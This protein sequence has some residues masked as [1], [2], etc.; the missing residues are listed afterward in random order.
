M[1]QRVR[2]TRMAAALAA[3]ASLGGCISAPT[4]QTLPPMCEASTDCDEAKGEWCGEGVCWG[5]PPAETGFAAVLVP[6][7]DRVDLPV[8][9]IPHLSIASD[10]NVTGLE[11]PD[12]V[13]VHGRVVLTCPEGP[14]G[15][16]PYPCGNQASVGAQILIERAPAFQGGPPY[17]RTVVAAAGVVPDQDA[18]SFLLPHDAE[19]EYRITIQPDDAVGGDDVASGEI[20]PPRQILL[21]A[22]KDRQVNWSIGE[23]SELKIIRGCV[24][25]V[26]GDGA[27]Y[28]GMK[29][30]AFGRWTQLSPLERASSRS[31][32]GEDGCFELSVPRNMLDQFDISVQPQPGVALPSFILRGEF[33]RDPADGEQVVHVIEPA[34]V[35]PIAPAPISFRLPV[36]APA[37]AGGQEPVFGAAVVLKTSFTP[38]TL[39]DQRTIEISYTA[40]AVTGAADSEEPGV[41]LLQ[42]Y[43]G[44]ENNRSYSVTILP[45]AGS[46]FQSAFEREVTVGTGSGVLQA[47]TLERRAAVSGFAIQASE[48]PVAD[49]SIEARP[50]SRFRQRLAEDV[51]ET[52]VAELPF[53]IATTDAD[54][55]FLLWLDR[56]LV[57][58]AASYDIDVMPPLYSGAPSWTFEDVA[59]PSSAE[60][61]ELGRKELPE[62]SYARAVVRDASGG[63]VVGAELHLYQL[64]PDDYCAGQTEVECQPTAKLRG[65]SRSDEEGVIRLVLPDP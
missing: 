39:N 1:A 42:L 32:T 16:M 15:A 56:E 20:A 62:A 28:A 30:V 57:G 24:Q 55:G 52:A 43:P 50:A 36:V 54:G 12:S 23:P 41:A 3:L 35:M 45:P 22:D 2:H 58:E 47:V 60:T 14:D 13:A 65:V 48:D 8:A 17:S 34:L 37:G 53:P 5:G 61:V 31:L 27:P 29:V 59:I 7:A 6:P 11:F 33:V 63:V 25:N 10:G 49:A 64:P 18:F 4:N 40:Q 9:M 51:L 46:Q 19:A 21:R 26:L 44:D 38:P